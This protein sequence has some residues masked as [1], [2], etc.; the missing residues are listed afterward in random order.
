[1]T[2]NRAS[3]AKTK[4]TAA[5]TEIGVISKRLQFSPGD[6]RGTSRTIQILAVPNLFQLQSVKLQTHLKDFPFKR[7]TP[8]MQ[9][10]TGSIPL[11]F[12]HWRLLLQL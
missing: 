11:P 12:N 10:Y 5:V 3:S 1:M 9:G 2:R 7:S 6:K 8:F 4:K